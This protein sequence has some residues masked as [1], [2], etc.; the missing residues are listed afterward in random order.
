M[1]GVEE[2]AAV[3]FKSLWFTASRFGSSEFLELCGSRF[4]GPGAKG[5]TMP[6]KL[7]AGLTYCCCLIKEYTGVM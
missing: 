3:G 5:P 2:L 6:H 1:V 7:G 4:R